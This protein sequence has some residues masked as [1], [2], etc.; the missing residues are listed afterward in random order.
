MWAPVFVLTGSWTP[1]GHV[2]RTMVLRKKPRPRTKMRASPP[3]SESPDTQSV[4]TDSLGPQS[5]AL[6]SGRLT[7]DRD[8]ACSREP[9]AWSCMTPGGPPDLACRHRD[10]ACLSV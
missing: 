10:D 9:S 4:S 2:H 8:P 3:L 6:T 1:E 5:T 7:R